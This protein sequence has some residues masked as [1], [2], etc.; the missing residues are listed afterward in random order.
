VAAR[1][2]AKEARRSADVAEQSVIAT[3][4]PWIS[5]DMTI[6]SPIKFPVEDDRNITL[7]IDAVCKNVGKSPAAHVRFNVSMSGG[8]SDSDAQVKSAID[9]AGK[10]YLVGIVFGGHPLFPDEKS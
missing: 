6:A 7:C 2:A 9:G 3:D 1:D 10:P 4:R 8:Y 5:I